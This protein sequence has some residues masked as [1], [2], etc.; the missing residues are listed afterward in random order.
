MIALWQRHITRTVRHPDSHVV[1][2]THKLPAPIVLSS[3]LLP[4]LTILCTLAYFSVR[5]VLYALS[6]IVFYTSVCILQ[7][8]PQAHTGQR[9]PQTYIP[10]SQYSAPAPSQPTYYG[11][12]PGTATRSL[13]LSVATEGC[14]LLSKLALSIQRCLSIQDTPL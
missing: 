2:G 1:I 4:L 9:M 5:T 3:A 8:P 6:L 10:S 11:N 14:G 12:C 7:Y 13:W